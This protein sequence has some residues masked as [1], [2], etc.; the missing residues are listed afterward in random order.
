MESSKPPRFHKEFCGE[1]LPNC[2]YFF[3][4]CVMTHFVYQFCFC[5]INLFTEVCGSA[6]GKGWPLTGCH[7]CSAVVCRQGYRL[8]CK[9]GPP[10]SQHLALRALSKLNFYTTSVGLLSP[11]CRPPT[12]AGALRPRI[13]QR[14][15]A[16]F[17]QSGTCGCD[18][19]SRILGLAH[20]EIGRR[21]A[22]YARSFQSRGP[23]RWTCTS[24][25]EKGLARAVAPFDPLSQRHCAQRR[26]S[27]TVCNTVCVGR[28]E[29]S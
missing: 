3:F 10:N 8:L 20:S 17:E 1:Q 15:L 18:G 4:R 28:S 25:L 16:D 22:L 14:R 6:C 26:C 9:S 2:V 23:P 7:G 12:M 13:Q 5:F 24:D 21:N 11:S 29:N 19:S 27:R